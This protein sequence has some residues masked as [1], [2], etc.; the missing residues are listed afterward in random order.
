MKKT[1]ALFFFMAIALGNILGQTKFATYMI[2]GCDESN[3]ETVR[4]KVT[5]NLVISGKYQLVDNFKVTDLRSL[6]GSFKTQTL[7]SEEDNDEQVKKAVNAAVKESNEF[8]E[9]VLEIVRQS[10]VE[11][12]CMVT[13][14]CSGN[15][16]NIDIQMIDVKSGQVLKTGKAEGSYNSLA[17]IEKVVNVATAGIVGTKETSNTQKKATTNY[18]EKQMPPAPPANGGYPVPPAPPAN[19]NHPVPPMP[20]ANGG[21]PVPPAPPTTQAQQD[22]PCSETAFGEIKSMIMDE[23]FAS[24]KLEIAKQA[25]KGEHLK[26]EQIRDIAKLLQ[27]ES[28]RVE[29]LTFAYEFCFD[30]NKYYLVNQAFQYSSSKD[31]LKEALGL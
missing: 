15:Y 3:T 31:E 12:L 8:L 2:Q 24:D 22:V 28:D 30:K 18:Q 19:G 27:Y 5:N 21:Y 11:Q 1:I 9:G 4:N 10:G 7:K 17:E 29:Y 25:T 23:K 20:P 13:V 26:A 16:I 14:L 6:M